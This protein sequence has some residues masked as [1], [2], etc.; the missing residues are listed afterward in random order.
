[1][2]KLLEKWRRS[3]TDRLG[4]DS[5]L[6]QAPAPTTPLRER[7]K[8]LSRLIHWARSKGTDTE[9]LPAA[10]LRYIFKI[11]ER[12]SNLKDQVAKT[13]RSI[14]HDTS[15]LELFMNIGI[16]NQ[17]G[18]WGEFF[19]RLQLR[20][21]PQPP[22]DNDLAFIFSETFKTASDVHW[23]Q[24]MDP[25]L[26]QDCID[27]FQFSK[28][29]VDPGWNTLISDARD[30]LHLLSHRVQSLGLSQMIRHRIP[31]NNFRELPF[32]QLGKTA[33]TLLAAKSEGD[34]SSSYR[35]LQLHISQ[36]FEIIE[37]VHE[38]FS[39]HGASLFLIYQIV[40]LQ[41]L[42]YRVQTL[43]QLIADYKNNPSIVK[44]FMSTLI[45]EN[46]RARSLKALFED[47]MVIIS[48]K[49]IETNAETGEHYITRDR[50]EYVTILK[51]ALGGGFITGFTI[52]LKFIILRMNVSLFMSGLLQSLN[53]AGSFLL[54]QATSFTLATKQPAMTATVISQKIPESGESIKP[55]LDEITHLIRSQLATVTGNLWGVIPTI[56]SID[57][58]FSVFNSH[59]T[60]AIHAE[61]VIESFSIL[62]MTPFY[63][64]LTG[65]LLWISSV[66]AGWFYNWF[67]FREIPEAVEHQS[68]LIYVFGTT[69]A[70]KIA[71]FLRK[72]MA[73]FASN[74]SLGFLLGM[75][76][77]IGA[78][79]GL[80]LDVRHVTLSTG[81]LVASAWVLGPEVFK[82]VPFYLGVLG[83]FS[84]AILNIAVSF[85]LALTV[86]IWS[87]RTFLRPN[88]QAVYRALL[89][90]FFTQ[91]WV[92]FLPIKKTRAQLKD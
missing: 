38:N 60:D 91:P 83:L 64:A 88:R 58:V 31:V 45:F 26:F 6:G 81:S 63:A 4:L 70:K 89:K 25:I 1:M 54:L 56:I 13:L 44:Q 3:S 69:G 85:G 17:E 11:L 49:I 68:R 9:N 87:K 29:T 90:R 82:A 12:N 52:L 71:D 47:N 51:K 15:A 37:Q 18:F 76:P 10:R 78:F 40:R 74:I 86:A 34:L 66:F 42:L 21:L 50:E 22:H 75:T 33:D 5:L 73:G 28:G 43:A 46:E 77:S 55:L 39:E 16:P 36:C 23:I 35:E 8:W 53:Y 41:M 14:I 92:F 57:L 80:P 61:H 24:Q 20:I 7:L 84:M 62:G 30:A 2:L 27:L 79:F 48:Q 72:N 59:V 67:C 19:D 65:V 32:F